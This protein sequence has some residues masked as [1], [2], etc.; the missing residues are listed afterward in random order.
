[1][2]PG[3]D[4]PV[5]P[6]APVPG[7]GAAASGTDDSA[8]YVEYCGERTELD[9]GRRFFIGR[10]ADLSIDDNPYL[11]RRFLVVHNENGLWWLTNLG[12]HLSASV[13]AGDVGFTATL[14][15]GAR[16][17]LVFGETTIVFTAGPTTYELSVFARAPQVKSVTRPEFSGGHTTQ[18]VPTL[19][20]SQ[21]LL[22]V[23]LAEEILRR[24]GTGASAIPSSAQAA[25]RLGWSL[26]KFNRKL[27]NVCDKLDQLGVS[28]MRGGGGKLASNRRTK[29]VEYAIA[30]RIVTR[31][32]LPL[33]DAEAAR[34]AAG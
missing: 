14:G 30:S 33:I 10:E 13:S 5:S 15:P 3:Q 19:T 1:M 21:K 20:E 32:D 26:T 12:T 23:V 18:G 24:E 27:D 9:P 17:P 8:T 31:A 29:L 2:N 16:M 4:S 7:P 22:I 11:H 25:R 6:A 28:G 34:N